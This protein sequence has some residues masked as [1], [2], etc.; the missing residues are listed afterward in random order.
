MRVS[1]A[2]NY[3]QEMS[4]DEE[5]V[6]AWWGREHFGDS[7]LTKGDDE[8]DSC[9]LDAW[10]AVVGDYDIQEWELSAIHDDIVYALQSWL[11][12]EGGE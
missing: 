12:A 4:P 6:I 7:I 1:Q 5:I 8:L 3:L 9:P 2:I 10:N 11:D